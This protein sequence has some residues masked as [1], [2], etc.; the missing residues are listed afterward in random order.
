MLTNI[1]HSLFNAW[2]LQALNLKFKGVCNYISSSF[3]YL[4][5]K[6]YRIIVYALFETTLGIAYEAYNFLLDAKDPRAHCGGAALPCHLTLAWVCN[7]YRHPNQRWLIARRACISRNMGVSYLYGLS[8][9]RFSI[10]TLFII[11]SP[12]FLPS[13]SQP[14]ERSEHLRLHLFLRQHLSTQMKNINHYLLYHYATT[15]RDSLHGALFS[16]ESLPKTK[17]LNQPEDNIK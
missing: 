13:P 10:I 9:A 14:S 3:P 6:K 1:T 7:I 16:F 5:K 11:L 4:N 15:I 8:L 2:S 17:A 12:S